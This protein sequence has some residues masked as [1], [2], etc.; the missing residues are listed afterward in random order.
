MN[1]SKEDLQTC[2]KLV[3]TRLKAL[4]SIQINSS[5]PQHAYNIPP[6]LKCLVDVNLTSIVL[7]CIYVNER[8]DQT[9]LAQQIVNDLCRLGVE[10]NLK[11]SQSQQEQIKMVLEHLKAC[12]LIK[13]YGM[14]KTLSY[15]RNSCSNAESCREA[16][17]TLTS[18]AG[19]RATQL[20]P[21]EW[22]ELMRDLRYLQANLYKNL[23]SYRE[24]NE[25]FL[26]TLMSSKN[27]DNINLAAEWL[28]DIFNVDK[29][30][31]V[32]L[33]INASENHFISGLFNSGI[34]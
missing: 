4:P 5:T 1:I 26:S 32:K 20:K 13:K 21:N 15:M 8:G 33:A 9:E 30:A 27:V 28:K 34:I 2:L 23:I 29:Q 12:E 25:I 10:P 16:L 6:Y 24:C 7:D 18:L 3:N 22:N 14:N 17:V 19:N 31:A 11:P